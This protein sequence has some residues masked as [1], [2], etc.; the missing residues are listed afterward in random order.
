MKR[1]NN[2]IFFEKMLLDIKSRFI[3]AAEMWQSGR[4]L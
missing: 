1:K 4:M 3:F 2:L